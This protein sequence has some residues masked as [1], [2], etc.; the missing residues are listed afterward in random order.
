MTFRVMIALTLTLILSYYGSSDAY[1]QRARPS[2]QD[3]VEENT[4]PP[5]AER[6]SRGGAAM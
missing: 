4:S 6:G 3:D 2:A 5:A 1:A